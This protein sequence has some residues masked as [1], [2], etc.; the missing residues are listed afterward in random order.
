MFV[1]ENISIQLYRF[2]YLKNDLVFYRVVLFN[3]VLSPGFSL[4]YIIKMIFFVR[5]DVKIPS[6]SP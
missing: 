2:S 4:F 3:S 1:Y 6:L 5:G